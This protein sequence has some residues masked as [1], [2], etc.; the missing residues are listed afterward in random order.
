MP[1]RGKVGRPK[2]PL[3]RAESVLTGRVRALLQLAHGGNLAEA[4]RVTGVPYP[5]LRELYVGRTVNPGVRTLQA[6]AEAYGLSLDWFRQPEEPE[7][8]PLLGRV[9]FVPPAGGAGSGRGQLREVMIPFAAWPMYEFFSRLEE[10]LAREPA[11]EDRAIVGA[12]SGEALLFRLTTF[13]LQPLLAAERAGAADAIVSAKEYEERV[14]G[15][16]AAAW[17]DRLTALGRMW[18][19]VLGEGAERRSAE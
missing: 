15:E 6:L 7:D 3:R 17:V 9:G 4:S 11:T 14:G 8:L 5:T 10:Q 19:V 2:H 18:A 1:R 12:A 13:L 16:R